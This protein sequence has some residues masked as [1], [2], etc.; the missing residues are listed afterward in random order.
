MQY[1]PYTDNLKTAVFDIETMGLSS[2]RDIIISASFCDEDG[3]NLRQY[4]CDDPES[5]YLL[6]TKII[7]E[8]ESLDA[9]ITYNGESFDVPFVMSRAKKYGLDD[10]FPYIWNIDVYRILRNYWAAGKLLPSLSQTSVENA[11]GISSLRTDTIDGGECIPLYNRYLA[12]GDEESKEKILLHNGDDIRQLARISSKLSFI[13][14]HQVIYENGCYLKAASEI[15]D[16]GSVGITLGRVH[17]GIDSFTVNAKTKAGMVP[18]SAFEEYFDLEYD[19]F[20]GAARLVIHTKTLEDYQYVDLS[21]MPVEISDFENMEGFAS[22]YLIVKQG[23]EIRYKEINAL[24]RS[25]IGK[26]VYE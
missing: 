22:N 9:L 15:E 7:E 18:L 10:G 12:K 20:S 26:I 6:I 3:E 5:E 23:N 19:Y 16:T 17:E 8:F 14:F 21:K 24:I 4:F 11:L 13:P 25:M 2:Q 1:N